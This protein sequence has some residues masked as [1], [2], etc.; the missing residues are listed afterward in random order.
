MKAA[1]FQRPGIAMTKISH[2]PRYI[3]IAA[4]LRME[5]VPKDPGPW[6]RRSRLRVDAVDRIEATI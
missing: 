4:A 6:P 2:P 1:D 5:S 3:A